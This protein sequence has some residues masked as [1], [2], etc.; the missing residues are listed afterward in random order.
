MVAVAQRQTLRIGG[1]WRRMYYVYILQ[2]T[3]DENLYTGF[4]EDLRKRL[5]DHNEGLNTSTK[6]R[7]PLKLIYYEAY[8]SE[9]D[10]RQREKFLKSGRGHEVLYKQLKQTLEK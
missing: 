2:S 10:A 4:T 1:L 5:I 6:Y 3:K 8:T 9:T 7:R